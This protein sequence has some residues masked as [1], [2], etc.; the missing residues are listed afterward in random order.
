MHGEISLLR[1][2]SVA[3]DG[4]DACPSA[5]TDGLV[6]SYIFGATG[7]TLNDLSGNGYDGQIHDA[8]SPSA[9]Y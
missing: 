4:V 5:A 8:V 7:A 3:T 2:W 6:A 9:C 1:I